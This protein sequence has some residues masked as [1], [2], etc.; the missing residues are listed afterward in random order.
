MQWG[1]RIGIQ[2]GSSHQAV[3]I[4]DPAKHQV[5]VSMDGRTVLVSVLVNGEPV[6]GDVV[7]AD[8][9]GGRPAISVVDQTDQTPQPTL[10][11]SLIG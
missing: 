11:Q 3:V 6:R 1:P 7:A 10:C 5:Q 4:T 8:H 9:T 2:S